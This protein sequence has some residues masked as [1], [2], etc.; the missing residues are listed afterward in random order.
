LF[1]AAFFFLPSLIRRGWG[2]WGKGSPRLPYLAKGEKGAAEHH[3]VLYAEK[4]SGSA[5]GRRLIAS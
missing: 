2:R 4:F 3:T 1:A 5:L